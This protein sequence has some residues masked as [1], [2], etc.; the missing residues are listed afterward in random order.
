MRG[1]TIFQ[2]SLRGHGLVIPAQ[3]ASH[4]IGTLR[5]L[6]VFARMRSKAILAQGANQ[7]RCQPRTSLVQSTISQTNFYSFTEPSRNS[8]ARLDA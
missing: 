8:Y 3:A 1:Y 6:T 2:E 5:G 7:G 4:V